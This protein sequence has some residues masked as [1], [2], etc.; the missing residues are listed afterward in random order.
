[1]ELPTVYSQ[2]FCNHVEVVNHISIGHH[3][4]YFIRLFC[5]TLHL[6]VIKEEN[7]EISPA[8]TL[9]RKPKFS[10]HFSKHQDIS[11]QEMSP[12]LR[13]SSS[14]NDL[15][16][17]IKEKLRTPPE[18]NWDRQSSIEMAR[19]S[20]DSMLTSQAAFTVLPPIN[21]ASEN[22]DE[23]H[24]RELL[25]CEDDPQHSQKEENGKPPDVVERRSQ[26]KSRAAK[27]DLILKLSE[28]F[29]INRVTQPKEF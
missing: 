19:R 5:R 16:A 28:Q 8:I 18:H 11:R 25:E 23:S 26:V 6:S 24:D 10:R 1:M 20:S 27:E 9:L 22:T 29:K 7:E 12:R 15:V 3:I 13:S 21:S 4:P 2:Q 17:N 14:V